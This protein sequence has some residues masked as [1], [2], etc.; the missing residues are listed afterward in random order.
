M[1]LWLSL[2]GYL[3]FNKCQVCVSHSKVRACKISESP[4]Y[5]THSKQTTALSFTIKKYILKVCT[6]I[7]HLFY[8]NDEQPMAS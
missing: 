8:K 1:S 5:Y 2:F 7:K 4:E 6:F 3:G